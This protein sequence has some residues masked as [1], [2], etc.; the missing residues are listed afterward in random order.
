[1]NKVLSIVLHFEANTQWKKSE[2]FQTFFK[3]FSA[4]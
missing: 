3:K 2:H 4:V 1:M